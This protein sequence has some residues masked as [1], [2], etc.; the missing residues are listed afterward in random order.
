MDVQ[1]ECANANVVFFSGASFM[2]VMKILQS[3]TGTKTIV[4][5]NRL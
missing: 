4:Q 5:S 3:V 1:A 2:N